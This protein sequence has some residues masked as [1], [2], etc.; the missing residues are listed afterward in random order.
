[1]TT[2]LCPASVLSRP[3]RCVLALL[4][5]VILLLPCVALAQDPSGPN[6]APPT[7]PTARDTLFQVSL[8]DAL[9]LGHYKGL[10]RIGQLKAHGNLG[11][12]TLEGLDGEL[13]LVDGVFYVIDVDGVVR[14][15]DDEEFVPFAAVTWFEPEH[16]LILD[17]VTSLEDLN[18]QIIAA[19]PDRNLFYALRLGPDFAWLKV[20]SVPRQNKPYPPLAEAVKQQRV[21]EYDSPRGDIVGFYCPAWAKG[22]NLPGLHLHY[23]SADRQSGGHV[24][25]LR[26]KRLAV[27]LDRTA[28]LFLVAPDDDP[29]FAS[30]PLN[31]PSGASLKGVEK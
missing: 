18:R 31:G 17:E 9:M 30:L 27:T 26:A 21:F 1:M 3:R 12:G 23:I 2:R 6:P 28:G 4:C 10:V 15:V 11:L 22:V 13:V 25:D 24:L 20:R 8:L 5:L 7:D 19:L 14:L 16:P 29:E